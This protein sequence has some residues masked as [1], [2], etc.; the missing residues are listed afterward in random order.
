[1][2]ALRQQAKMFR[3]FMPA[4]LMALGVLLV[5]AHALGAPVPMLRGPIND[6]AA[7]LG[8]QGAA[9]AERL[10]RV[11]RAYGV[12]LVVLTVPSLDGEPIAAFAHRVTQAWRVGEAKT[13]T[14]LLLLIAPQERQTR[15][16]VGYGLEGIVPDATAKRILAEN[17]RPAAPGAALGGPEVMRT[18]EA[19][20]TLF[21]AAHAKGLLPVVAVGV[22]GGSFYSERGM[23]MVVTAAALI[24]MALFLLR[25]LPANT[26]VDPSRPDTAFTGIG[27]HRA[28][29]GG[30]MPWRL[31]AW[32][33]AIITRSS[34][35]GGSGL[36]D[37]RGSGGSGDDDRYSGG[38]GNFGGGGSSDR[39]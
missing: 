6:N 36:G 20:E 7:I 9:M 10:T 15:L 19:F 5:S 29:V 21:A 14:G 1:M 33:L 17:L 11:N 22:S 32:L 38:G 30:G 39:Y 31:I 2:G 25:R 35:G 34:R 24:F 23:L 13:D 26:R 28:G 3:P 12:Q 8:Y 37:S 16:E 18:L 4:A 27:A